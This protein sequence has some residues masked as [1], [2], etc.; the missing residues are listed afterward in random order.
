M[1]ETVT[2]A[3]KKFPK[4]AVLVGGAGVAGIVGY[5]WF[6]KGRNQPAPPALPEPVP[7]P[8]DTPGFGADI[9]N[10]AAPGTNDAW[11]NLAVA[12]AIGI[13]L[14]GGSVAEALGMFL[15]QQRL[16]KTQASLVRT[17]IGLA[18]Y[19]PV[20]P[21]GGGS[22]VV[23]EQDTGGTTPP[24]VEPPPTQPPPVQPPPAIGPPATPTRFAAGGDRGGVWLAWDPVAG[25]DSYEISRMEANSRTPWMN[26]GN[27]TALF[28]Q[29][30]VSVD[31][32]YAYAVRAHGPGGYSGEAHSAPVWILA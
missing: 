7:E 15:A 26:V 14:D 22:W 1:P 21:P 20:G 2:I 13:G 23:L 11:V 9:N 6:S 32:Q 17:A 16:T 28:H 18:G 4:N 30:L 19:P 31:T 8:T 24:P 3:G 10:G 5:A 25:A 27:R 29:Q 12:R